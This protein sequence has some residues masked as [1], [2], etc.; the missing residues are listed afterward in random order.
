MERTYLSIQY[1]IRIKIENGNTSLAHLYYLVEP[2]KSYYLLIIAIKS[3][4]N[5][6][7]AL[8]RVDITKMPLQLNN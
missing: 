7:D 8:K 4:Q 1:F 2:S 5:N 3:F 6:K